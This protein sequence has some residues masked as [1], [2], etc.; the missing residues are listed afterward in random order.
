ME[1]RISGSQHKRY[2]KQNTAYVC[3]LVKQVEPLLTLACL[4]VLCDDQAV[5]GV[6]VAAKGPGVVHTASLSFAG[7]VLTLVDIYKPQAN[8]LALN[9]QTKETTAAGVESSSCAT[10]DSNYH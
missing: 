8:A 9:Y 1:V 2:I 5:S 3:L 4:L 7:V 6:T 10:W